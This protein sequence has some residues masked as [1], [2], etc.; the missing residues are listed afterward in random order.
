MI[1]L[2]AI[3][4][5]ESQVVQN[6]NGHATKF[7]Q[8]LVP[9]DSKNFNKFLVIYCYNSS[10]KIVVTKHIIIMDDIQKQ[11]EEF[12]NL[13]KNSNA[14]FVEV[15]SIVRSGVQQ[16]QKDTPIYENGT[17][18]GIMKMLD[19]AQ[20]TYDS[21]EMQKLLVRMIILELVNPEI[22]KQLNYSEVIQNLFEK[23]YT[24]ELRKL[25]CDSEEIQALLEQHN[26]LVSVRKSVPLK[27]MEKNFQY[28]DDQMRENP[29][30]EVEL[31]PKFCEAQALLESARD[32]YHNVGLQIVRTNSKLADCITALKCKM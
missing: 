26:H 3:N 21:K 11:F 7:V 2:Y 9:T 32:K 5:I 29:G 20:P 12:N 4:I 6:F 24:P 14:Q 10:F 13:T 23:Q 18:P 8:I 27:D 25:I 15:S 16:M 31:R 30:F 17:A 19:D 1:V 22:K 28:A